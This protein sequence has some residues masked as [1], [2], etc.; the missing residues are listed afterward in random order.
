M[1]KDKD[2]LGH[3]SIMTHAQIVRRAK[4]IV[5]A[6]LD[7]RDKAIAEAQGMLCVVS[8]VM[9]KTGGEIIL[10]QD[11]LDNAPRNLAFEQDEAGNRRIVPFEMR[12]TEETASGDDIVH[13]PGCVPGSGCV[14]DPTTGCVRVPRQITAPPEQKL[15]TATT[16]ETPAI[17]RETSNGSKIEL[18]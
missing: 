3:T 8:A 7:E 9:M 2:S 12:V 15:L 14:G 4:A 10:T 16:G 5:Q 1:S 6:A 13:G 18:L 11:D 17:S